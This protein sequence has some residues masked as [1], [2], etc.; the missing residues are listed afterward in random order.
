MADLAVLNK[1]SGSGAASV[2]QEQS[3]LTV[4]D[5][6]VVYGDGDNARTA[7]KSA[8]F[9]IRRGERVAVIGESGSGKTTMALAVAGLLT[10]AAAGITTEKIVFAGKQLNRE[11]PRKVPFRTP[12]LSMVFQDA[13]TS[14]DPVA[15]I[16][17][18]FRAVLR[19]V[20]KI[21]R[22]EAGARATQWLVRVG[23]P[24]PGRV[25]NLRPYELSGGMRQ[26][27]MVALAMC[28][29]PELLIADEPTSALDAS[30]SRDVME[31]MVE[32]TDQEG[33][34]LLI[35]THDIELCRK[36]TDRLIVMYHGE[37]VD[38]CQTEHI[39]EEATHPYTRALLACVPTLDAA[40]LDRLPTLEQFMPDPGEHAEST[41]GSAAA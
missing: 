4:T 33:A 25:M 19:G 34:S 16:G 27:V 14:L 12:G 9:D 30:V 26:R 38:I 41:E 29:C 18:Q 35:V 31:L 2:D 5:L 40:G 11:R 37:I 39:E 20:S 23:M 21:S 22:K 6:T 3:L 24:D 17:S 7:V 13:M 32:M 8:S 1:E 28:G 10:A 36:Y 15:T